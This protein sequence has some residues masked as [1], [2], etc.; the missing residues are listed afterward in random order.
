MEPSRSPCLLGIFLGHADD[1]AWAAMEELHGFFP[2]GAAGVN[3]ELL[4]VGS[5]RDGGI[6][7]GLETELWW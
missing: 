1:G 3:E 6:V 4:E 7:V 2:D 5:I